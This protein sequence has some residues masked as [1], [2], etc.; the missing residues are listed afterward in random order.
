MKAIV[1]REKGEKVHGGR[2]EMRGV[3]FVSNLDFKI[4]SFRT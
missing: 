1:E 2:K 4:S 3:D